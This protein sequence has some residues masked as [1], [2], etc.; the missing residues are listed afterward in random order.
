MSKDFLDSNIIVYANDA[1]DRRKQDLAIE[2]VARGLRD[3]TAV[4]STQVLQEYAVNAVG[5][6]RQELPV[7]MHQLKLLEFLPIVAATPKLVRR[8]LEV[9]GLYGINFWDAL[10]VAA[11]E[12]ARCDRILSEDLNPGQFYCGM[13][14]VNPFQP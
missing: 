8:G 9:S 12:H 10:I 1:A 14:C 2:I 6:L 3:G 13:D 11:A 4:I 5:K 7:V